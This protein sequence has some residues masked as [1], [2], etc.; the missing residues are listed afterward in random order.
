MNKPIGFVISIST[1]IRYDVKYVSEKHEV[2]LVRDSGMEQLVGTKVTS[3]DDALN[4]AQ[5]FI[6]DNP[7]TY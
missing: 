5:R 6:D 4:F 3:K 7:N 2:W 1:N